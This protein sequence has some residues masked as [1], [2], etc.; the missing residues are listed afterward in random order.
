MS[1]SPIENFDAPVKRSILKNFSDIELAQYSHTYPRLTDDVEKCYRQR[2]RTEGFTITDDNFA[3]VPEVLSTFGGHIQELC[4]HVTYIQKE[5]NVAN[6][7]QVCS[8][9]NDSFQNLEKITLKALNI[10]YGSAVLGCLFDV[11]HRHKNTITAMFFDCYLDPDDEQF[12]KQTVK[13]FVQERHR[14]NF[15]YSVG[16]N[17]VPKMFS[18]FNAQQNF[19]KF[20]PI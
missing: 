7:E 15:H 12:W 17:G 18:Q 14:F 2:L 13:G 3:N 4:R 8:W 6:V 19:I 16:P 20:I 10:F 1:T 9:W 11:V 5:R